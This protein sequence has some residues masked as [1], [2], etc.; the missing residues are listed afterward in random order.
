MRA[1]VGQ[2]V[3]ENELCPRFFL[4]MAENPAVFTADCAKSCIA[5]SRPAPRGHPT[6]AYQRPEKASLRRFVRRALVLLALAVLAVVWPATQLI[7]GDAKTIPEWTWRSTDVQGGLSLCWN[8]CGVCFAAELW[9]KRWTSGEENYRKSLLTPQPRR[10]R[11]SFNRFDT[12][13]ATS[14]I[15]AEQIGSV[16]HLP[17][18]RMSALGVHVRWHRERSTHVDPWTYARAAF[19]RGAVQLTLPSWLIAAASVSGLV[20]LVRAEYRWWNGAAARDRP[21]D[22]AVAAV[23]G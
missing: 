8:R 11:F 13:P 16:M 5:A 9:R 21:V 3:P 14:T 22:D 4:L 19:S 17:Q 23:C 6:L 2:P 15:T 18:T 10:L 7:G 12:V 20:L 1:V